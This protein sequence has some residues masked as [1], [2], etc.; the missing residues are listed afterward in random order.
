MQRSKITID[1]HA[2]AHT[3]C[4]CH[5]CTYKALWIFLTTQ[6]FHKTAKFNSE[7]YYLII[8]YTLTLAR[9]R[10]HINVS[11]S[12]SAR[13]RQHVNV[14]TSTSARQC[15]HVT[16]ALNKAM[17]YSN[18]HLC[19]FSNWMHLSHCELKHLLGRSGESPIEGT[20][21]CA[22]MCVCIKIMYNSNL[23]I[24]LLI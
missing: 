22:H 2:H 9:Q 15:Q 1:T 16:Y 14:S 7:Y 12:M 23:R 4:W 3:Q 11:T 20:C 19:A 6:K 21:V 10:Q 13:Q 18:R 17:V 5:K 8:P 24:T